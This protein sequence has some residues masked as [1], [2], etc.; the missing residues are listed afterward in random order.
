VLAVIVL[1]TW[2]PVRST[3][4]TL[5]LVPELIELPVRPLSAVMPEPL[6]VST[7]YGQPADR[8]DVY[9]P[10]GEGSD[11]RAPAVVLELGVH[12]QPIDHPDVTRIA[13]AISRLGVV[14]AVP[15]STPLRNLVLTA[16]EPGHLADAV[17]AVRAMG[18]VDPERLGIAGFSAGASI[19]LITAADPR[20]ANE[21]AFVSA[22]GGYAHAEELLIDV[23]TNTAVVDGQVR[24]WPADAGIRADIATLLTGRQH[25][26]EDS[27][28]VARLMS[29]PD[30][31][32]ARAAI[33]DFS[34]ELRAELNALSPVSFADQVRAPVFILHGEPDTAIPVSHASQLAQAL[35]DEVVRVT[36]FGRFGHGQPG[37]D[38]LGIDDAGDIVALSAYLRDIVAAATE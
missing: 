4:L 31:A 27:E 24:E 13:R 8:M 14:V 35:G 19:A 26:P 30:R 23:A 12:P 37:A 25:T 6:R 36:R 28:A 5:A 33:D 20:L 38:G 1:P 16:D 11:V 22:F 3:V 9:L 17:L 29:A 21:V 10:Y 34:A 18:Q 15:D 2:G 32:T 7:T